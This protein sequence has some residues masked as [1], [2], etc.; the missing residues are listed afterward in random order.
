MSTLKHILYYNYDI[1]TFKIQKPSEVYFIGP[2]QTH[3]KITNLDK[4][5]K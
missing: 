3:S 5:H 2:R 4:N 1:I